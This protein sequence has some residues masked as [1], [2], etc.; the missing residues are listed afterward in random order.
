MRDNEKK[1]PG[2]LNKN[3]QKKLFLWLIFV[4]SIIIIGVEVS[5]EIK[6]EKRRESEILSAQR[7]EQE[8]D[9]QIEEYRSELLDLKTDYVREISAKSCVV[10]CFDQ[11]GRSAYSDI[12][13][14]MDKYGFTGVIIFRDGQVPGNKGSISV[15][16]YQQLLDKGWEGAIGNS[17]EIFVY[18]NFPEIKK[19]KWLEYMREMQ[20]SFERNGLPVPSVYIPHKKESVDELEDM[21]IQLGMKAY[22]TVGSETAGVYDTATDMN[23][24]P[25]LNMGMIVG[26]YRYESLGEDMKLLLPEAKSLAVW[27]RKVENGAPDNGQYTSI[28][29]FRQQLE[30]L[31]ILREYVNVITFSEY[32]EYQ[33]ALL[34]NNRE[35]YKDFQASQDRLL[36]KITQAD[37][38][39][40]ENYARAVK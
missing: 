15:E 16:L 34:E 29:M 13:K 6:S 14:E 11:F 17:D 22:A 3:I 30:S 24:E 40:A 7:K 23:T 8:L 28:Y 12:I 19:K 5:Y 26:K 27:Y 35:I 38:E 18:D 2:K 9:R 33:S 31:S 25:L 10:L 4:I 20:S 37:L 21:L 32:Q 39:A 1:E 36:R